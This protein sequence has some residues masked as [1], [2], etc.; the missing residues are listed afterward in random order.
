MR[1]HGDFFPDLYHHDVWNC[2]SV[3]QLSPARMRISYKTNLH[4]TLAT[5][6]LQR[7]RGSTVDAISRVHQA[8]AVE[9]TN[10]PKEGICKVSNPRPAFALIYFVDQSWG[11]RVKDLS[12]SKVLHARDVARHSVRS[13]ARSNCMSCT[14]PAYTTLE[15]LRSCDFCCYHGIC[16]RSI[17]VQRMHRYIE[18]HWCA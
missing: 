5:M 2:G 12:Y 16:R 10:L 14:P 8:A 15:Q 6:V 13:S 9:L 17:P 1:L 18:H 11:C 7:S 3:L 4:L